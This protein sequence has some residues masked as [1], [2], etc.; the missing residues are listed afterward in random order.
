MQRQRC[1]A[2]W[3]AQNRRSLPH[4]GMR[5]GRSARPDRLVPHGRGARNTCTC[6]T[7]ETKRRTRNASPPTPQT[8]STPTQLPLTN[9]SSEVQGL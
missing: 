2:A 6:A 9:C 7:V 5:G 8:A 4:L 1:G 3:R